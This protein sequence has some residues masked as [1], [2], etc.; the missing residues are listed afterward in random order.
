MAQKFCVAMVS[1]VSSEDEDDSA[2]ASLL[3]KEKG[4]C[5]RS[6]V[7]SPHGGPKP[8]KLKTES[9]RGKHTIVQ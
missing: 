4:K 7:R 1:D 3:V 2:P 5:I 8:K 6:P 9:T